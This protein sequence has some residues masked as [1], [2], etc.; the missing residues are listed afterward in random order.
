MCTSFGLPF[1]QRL[2]FPAGAK[3]PKMKHQRAHRAEHSRV[4]WNRALKLERGLVLGPDG[5]RVPHSHTVSQLCCF[6]IGLFTLNKVSFFTDPKLGI[7]VGNNHHLTPCSHRSSKARL[8]F[9]FVSVKYYEIIFL[10]IN[11]PC[12]EWFFELAY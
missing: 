12:L 9:I 2:Q 3:T 7:P 6:I 1:H 10:L 4:A 11:Y 8:F 5:P